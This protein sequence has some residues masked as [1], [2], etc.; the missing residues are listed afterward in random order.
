MS[1]N[2]NIRNT[3]AWPCVSGRFI[4]TRCLFAVSSTRASFEFCWRLRYL[5]VFFWSLLLQCRVILFSAPNRE[6][7]WYLSFSGGLV[8]TAVRQ[9]R[10]QMIISWS[11]RISLQ[12][13]YSVVVCCSCLHKYPATDCKLKLRYG[14]YII[15]KERPCKVDYRIDSLCCKEEIQRNRSSDICS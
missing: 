6:K 14:R 15:D 7:F 10:C 12:C 5:S 13:S 11:L 2:L 9:V 4:L 3:S 8:T 1:N